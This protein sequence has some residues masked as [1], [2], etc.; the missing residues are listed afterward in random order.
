M[1]IS[2]KTCMDAWKKA[3]KYII[4]N[5]SDFID[6]DNRKCRE[7]V[8]LM[9]KIENPESDYEKI[10]DLMKQF[11]W[12]YP[13]TEE[14]SNIM[15]NKEESSMYEYS[16]GPRLFNFLGKK[17]QVNDYIIPMLKN[18][19]KTRR[20]VISLFNPYTDSDM[21]NDNI[22]SLMFIH[23]KIVNN[24][25]NCTFFVRSNEFFIGCPSDIYQMYL[26]QKYVADKVNIKTGSLTTVSCSAH[27]FHEHFD[28][29][30]KVI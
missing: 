9:I 10:I 25:L 6:F 22:P 3:L 29:I 13:T 20:A 1:I 14:L 16:Y 23:F 28:R 5:G 18:Y 24:K 12:I 2:E 17:D 19:P 21:H 26:L 11:D 8:N 27:I 15:F 7:A 30:N 4:D